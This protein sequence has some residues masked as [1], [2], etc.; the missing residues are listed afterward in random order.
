M[1]ESRD[2]SKYSDAELL[3]VVREA[4]KQGIEDDYIVMEMDVSDDLLA[5]AES[6][7]DRLMLEPS[8]QPIDTAPKD[9]SAILTDAGIVR[10]MD[11]A[12]W[13]SPVKSG[14]WAACDTHG[15]VYT[16]PSDDMYEEQPTV[17]VPLPDFTD[18]KENL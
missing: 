1:N 13:G 8:M 2:T 9:G 15:S 7:L 3:E 5:A 10:Y 18:R 17:W 12:H 4:A 16:S 11:Q 6:S 14:V